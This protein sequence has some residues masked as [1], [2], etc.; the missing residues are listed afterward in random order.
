MRKSITVVVGMVLATGLVL[1]QGHENARE[2]DARDTI[3]LGAD[4]RV[5]PHQLPAGEYRVVCNREHVSFTQTGAGKATFRM[6]CDGALL[7]EARTTSEVHTTMR[8]DGVRVISK[9]YLRGSNVEHV[10]K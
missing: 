2:R 9:L 5:G 7:S 1:A 3:V 8:P 6:P 4:V 10:F